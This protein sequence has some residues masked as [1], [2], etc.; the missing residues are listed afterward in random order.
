M[1]LYLSINFCTTIALINNNTYN[2]T[3]IESRF[4]FTFLL[5]VSSLSRAN[6]PL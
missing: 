6:F 3:K 5:T 4:K 2:K 1:V